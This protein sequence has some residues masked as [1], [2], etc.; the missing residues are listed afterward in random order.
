MQRIEEW[1]G[2]LGLGEYAS[3]FV[4]NDIDP[5]IV[6]E[7]TDLDLEKIGVASL[8]HRR[9]LLRAISEL[10]ASLAETVS[11]VK[12]Q[13]SERLIASAEP[14]PLPAVDVAG[15]RRYLTVLFCDLVDS[16]RIASRL[17]AEEWRGLVGAYFEVASAA[18]TEMGGTVAKKL[19]DGLM[20]LFGY[21]TA[22]ENDAERAARAALAIQR[23]IGELNHKSA[24]IGKPELNARIGLETG[25]VVVD[26]T[27]EVYGDVP[28]TAARVEALAEPGAIVITGQT[29][30]Q[31]TGLFVAEERGAHE[32]KGL[33]EPVTLFRLVR[34]SGGGRRSGTRQLTRLFGREEEMA[35]LMRRWER[36]RQGAGQLVLVV[37]EPGLGKSRLIEE[38]HRRLRDTQHTWLEWN[39]SQLLQN[40]PLHP[41]A[42]WGRQRFGG[43]D[44]SAERRFGELESALAQVKLDPAENAPLLAPLLDIPLPQGRAPTL[45]PD[46]LR[47]RQLAA[48]TG[49]VIAG[50]RVQP[51]VLAIED[52]H[53][54]DP[55]TLDVLRGMAGP[56][57]LAPLFIVAT[58]RP[59]FRPP[60][61]MRSHHATI[62]LAPLDRA[63]VQDM[64]VEL[65]ARH[66]L[67]REVVDDVAER[68]GGVPL[69]VEEVTR[70]LVERGEK[71][72]IHVIPPSLQQSLMARL[73]RLGPP[74]EVAQVASV[75]G[76]G[77]SYGL[78]RA[79]TGMADAALQTALEQLVEADILLVQGLPPESDYRFKHALI[80]DAAYENLLKSRRH[81]LHRRVAETLRCRFP[82]TAK[83]EPEVLAHHFAQAGLT[84]AAIEW[85]GKAGDQA[86]RRSAFQE[87]ISH[88][89]R[90]IEMADKTGEGGYDAATALASTNQRLKLQTDLGKALMFSRGYAAEES[91]AAFI[92]ARDLAAV[93]DDPTERFTV[94]YGLWVGNLVRGEL[95]LAREIAETFLREAEREARTTECGVG[96]RIVGLTCLF[97]GDFN[98]AQA[99]LV[100]ALSTC[101]PEQDREAR[102]RFAADIAATARAFLAVTNWLLGEVGAARALI[103]EAVARAIEADH[104]ITLVNTYMFRAHFETVRGDAEAVLRSAEIVIKL[105]QEN[106]LALYAAMGTLQSAWARARL[107]GTEGGVTGLRRALAAF[108]SQ[109]NKFHVPFYQ[110]L[111]A[112]IEAQ[113]DAAGALTRIDAALALAG[114]TGERWSDAF[115]YRLRGEILLKRDPANKAPAE[116]AF[117]T[118]IAVAQQQKAR[119]FELC[120]ALGLA[121]LYYSTS[122]FADAYSL[123]GPVLEGFSPAPEFPEIAEAHSLLAALAETDEVKNAAAARQRRLK[124]QTSLGQALMFSRGY[125]ADESQAAFI[126][127]RELAAASDNPAERF[128]IYYGLRITNA[129]R[130]ELG[131]AREIAEKFLREAEREARTTEYGVGRHLVGYSCLW[132][133]DLIEAQANLVE[134][135][136]TYDPERDREAMY[137]FGGDI[138]AIARVNL[139]MTKWLLSEVGPARA[140]IKEAVAHAIETDHVTSLVRT[141]MFKAQFE[142][143]RGD[144]ATA[145]RDAE[146]VVKLSR[147][148]AISEYAALG[149]IQSAWASARLDGSGTG[150]TELRE[151][152]AARFGQGNKFQA[153]FFQG[154]LAEIEA[155]GDAAGALTRIDE[156][157]DLACE[158]GEHWSDA[159]LHRLRGE[160]LLKRDPAN[161]ALAEDA[162]LT[163]I[164]IAQ[165]QKARSFELRAA[166]GLARLYNSTSRSADA[167]ALLAPTLEGVVSTPELP[168]IGQAKTLLSALA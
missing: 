160:I 134:A 52:L 54:A 21:P 79:L 56:G 91:K 64:I 125:G 129:A 46:E 103:E 105:G 19:G 113:G 36:A 164:A 73:D 20:A 60:W 100:E 58:T 137:R 9:K 115:L 104:V 124:L 40:T 136:S 12:P 17:D 26:A 76:R 78:L 110:G 108:A 92:R 123:L 48:V 16:T 120:A 158:T 71:G 143:V 18:V 1:L 24:A 81:V 44:V 27:G 47:R 119:S 138:G 147:E 84:D 22:H 14:E 98:E 80:Q 148:N 8:G 132:E 70:L 165:Q 133:G 101:Y 6:R 35:M 7:L 118:A 130:G 28:N 4:E 89:G 117:L 55:T 2:D 142:M 59:E 106:V 25:P 140:L 127:A 88:L 11:A 87:A 86:L 167:H 3:R 31:I 69:F 66:A 94:Y 107:D 116:D 5:S 75:I 150:A 159:F 67:P 166:L 154:S 141:Y 15:E 42:E 45:A 146:I 145:R 82:D 85:W 51:V 128:D 111:L 131:L 62:S 162:F 90:A 139:G 156:A 68:T 157:L 13:A 29:Q 96:R 153:P 102:F 41:M 152:L 135:L 163:A 161:T 121:R 83:A 168:E 43:A 109:G 10:N 126:R 30:R 93:I 61:G 33:K 95:G 34:A 49:A 99:N 155:Q 112:E 23:A 144:A 77:F 114:E 57:A 74:R 32:L 50:A 72:G 149:A 122:R 53:W 39:G 37:G 97:Q 63:Q 65:S 38:F 151:A